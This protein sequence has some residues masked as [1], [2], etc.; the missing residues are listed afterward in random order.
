M[1]MMKTKTMKRYSV[2]FKQQ[3]VSEYEAGQSA[4]VLRGKYGLTGRRNGRATRPATAK[5]SS[6]M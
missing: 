5:G 2:A 4:N 3:V 1:E 6:A